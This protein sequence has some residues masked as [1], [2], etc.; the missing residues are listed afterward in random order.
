MS[1]PIAH[2]HFRQEQRIREKMVALNAQIRIES[3]H[4]ILRAIEVGDR[5]G[6]A[7][8]LLGGGDNAQE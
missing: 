7:E 6:I 4:H 3:E 2:Y 5:T 1:S 8:S